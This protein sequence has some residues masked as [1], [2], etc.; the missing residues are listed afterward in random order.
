MNSS[1]KCGLVTLLLVGSGACNN[2]NFSTT[3]PK[4]IKK[5]NRERVKI[6]LPIIKKSWFFYGKEFDA[7]K[8]KRNDTSLPCKRVQRNF[9]DGPILWEEDY[10]YSGAAFREINGGTVQ[11]QLTIHYDYQVK[12]FYLSYIGTNAAMEAKLGGLQLTKSGAMGNSN[13]GTL[14]IA[15]S[16]LL[17]WQIPRV[18]P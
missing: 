2:G 17:Q 5:T 10:Y 6:G 7:E 14:E 1:L 9:N 4:E 15:D 13:E 16:I 18:V 11:E 8:W 12:K 3:L